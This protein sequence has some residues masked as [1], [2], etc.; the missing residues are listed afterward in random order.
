MDL[1]KT[2]CSN[3]ML[4]FT[5]PIDTPY[6]IHYSRPHSWIQSPITDKDTATSDPTKGPPRTADPLM[7]VSV[8]NWPNISSLYMQEDAG[9]EMACI[10]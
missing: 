7:L 3:I 5:S 10:S 6:M 4:S 8:H 9:S 1:L 2:L